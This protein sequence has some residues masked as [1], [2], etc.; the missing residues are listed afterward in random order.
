MRDEIATE[1]YKQIKDGAT[2]MHYVADQILAL[3][4]KPIPVRLKCERCEDGQV[5]VR[6]SEGD[7]N[8]LCTCDNGERV[9]HVMWEID[10][11]VGPGIREGESVN[12][13]IIKPLTPTDLVDPDI[14]EALVTFEKAIAKYGDITK[15]RGKS[16]YQE[17]PHNKGTLRLQEIA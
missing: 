16:Y 3:V 12:Y 9:H 15:W 1:L 13:E 11:G 17:I 5:Y 8:E 4:N 10:R 2:N 14:R 7:Y 6:S